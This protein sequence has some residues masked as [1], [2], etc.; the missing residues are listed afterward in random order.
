MGREQ[1]LELQSRHVRVHA[2]E[3]VQSSWSVCSL[4]S[5]PST[6]KRR[7]SMF[8]MSWAMAFTDANTNPRLFALALPASMPLELLGRLIAIGFESLPNSPNFP[9]TALRR[10]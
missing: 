7:Q 10:P 5:L 6:W 1:I 4:S 3:Q 2:V 9:P 8:M